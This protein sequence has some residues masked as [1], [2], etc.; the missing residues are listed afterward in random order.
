M[1]PHE[2]S[3]AVSRSLSDVFGTTAIED[4]CRMTKGLSSDLMFRIVVKGSPF[5]LRIMMR[6]DERNDPA[7][8][9]PCMKAAA[10]A[11][12][13]PRVLYSSME[14]GVAII[15]W[16]EAVP[17]P[18]AS[19][20]VRL[21]TTLRRLHVLPPFPKAFNYTTAHNFFIWRLPASGLLPE[22]EIEEVFR[23]YKEICA[24]TLAS[25]RT[26]FLATWI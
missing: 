25:T 23:R 15:D 5:L 13:A 14:D 7:R 20:L 12:L 26:W 11:G 22:Q 3:A 4:I 6:M 21:P 16:I 2:K 1:I 9:F 17:L 19:A 18:A 8:V 24:S 10:E